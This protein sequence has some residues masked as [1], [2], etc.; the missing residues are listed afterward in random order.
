[1]EG[2]GGGGGGGGGGERGGTTTNMLRA[3]WQLD[4]AVAE[5]ALTELS[6]S[7]K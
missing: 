1:M 2:Q 3:P 6:R 5:S 7:L 4:S